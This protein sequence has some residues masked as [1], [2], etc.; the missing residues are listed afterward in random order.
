M[1]KE[2]IVRRFS[3]AAVSYEEEATVQRQIAAR[4][5]DLLKISIS[6]ERYRNVLEIGCGTGLFS[7]MLQKQIFP[8]RM[9]LNDICPEMENSLDD[10]LGADICFR[11]GDA[12]TYPFS[13]GYDMITSCSAIQWFKEPA[14]FFKKAYNL[15][16]PGGVLAFST[17]G[18]DNLQEI[19]SV[20]GQGLTYPSLCELQEWLSSQYE[21]L[22]ISEERILKTLDS[23]MEVLYHLKRTGVT[24]IKQQKWTKTHLQSFCAEYNR[25]YN[26]GQSVTLTY[27][28]IFLIARKKDL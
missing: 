24:G 16:A 13:G 7:R 20:T 12:E 5:I 14:V 23:P 22:H 6:A 15:L 25:L 11:A 9:L 17:F 10:L 8:Q 28:P 21:I 27:H 2:L 3:R 18:E 4:M 1:N 19:T 26:T